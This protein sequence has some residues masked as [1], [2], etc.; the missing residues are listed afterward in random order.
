M[1]HVPPGPFSAES[2][3]D[4]L[5]GPEHR[6]ARTRSADLDPH[7]LGQLGEDLACDFLTRQGLEVLDRNVR[8]GRGELDVIV[9]SGGDRIA[10]EVKTLSTPGDDPFRTFTPAKQR[11]VNNLAR[12][13]KCRRCDLLVV[14]L[15]AD[16]VLFRWLPNP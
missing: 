8:V 13:V 2:P 12:Q 4:E 3:R 15:H 10:V 1:G 11:Q 16:G 9:R 5:P 7:Q 14:E 6:R